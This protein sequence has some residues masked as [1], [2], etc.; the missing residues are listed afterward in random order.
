MAA[1][2][3]LDFTGANDA[4]IRALDRAMP[5]ADAL[6]DYSEERSF[7]AEFAE[8]Q[9]LYGGYQEFSFLDFDGNGRLTTADAD[10]AAD[11]IID[12]V[13]QDFAP[14]NVNVLRMDDSFE[15]IRRARS[16]RQGDAIIVLV[17][18]H[19]GSG[20]QAPVDEGNRRDD[21]AIVGG[22]VGVAVGIADASWSNPHKAD[23]FVNQVANFVSHEAGHTFGLSHVDVTVHPGETALMT[24]TVG[25]N[26]LN[27]P[28]RLFC[29][30]GGDHQNAHKELTKVLG[31]STRP[32]A[33]VLTPGVL[34]VEGSSLDNVL[35][36]GRKSNGTWTVTTRSAFWG[37]SSTSTYH[38]DP[39]ASPDI[40]S[41]NPFSKAISRIVIHG[42]SGDD[43][44]RIDSRITAPLYAYG[45][46]G[47]DVIQGGAANDHLYGQMGADILV[48]R[49]G[50]DDLWGDSP[51]Q[52]MQ[53]DILI[54]GSGSD[55]L[56]GGPGEDVMVGGSTRYDSS[57]SSLERLMAEWDSATVRS[58]R[59]A[60]LNGTVSG[61]LNGSTTLTST[62]VRD[63][64][65]F[66][67]VYSQETDWL[68]A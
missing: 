52:G 58:L 43:Q 35:T 28:D 44:L 32:W 1:D 6:R 37:R 56:R 17:G 25:V 40:N 39:D 16:N 33:A 7:V 21:A 62:S 66:D 24:P 54:G 51:M 29:V 42:G 3:M 55:T 46:S 8:L 57:V 63:D 11:R 64:D 53:R 2:I 61:G 15:A 22:S 45:G 19:D 10:L 47:D 14:Y 50:N 13:K 38:V 36:V 48:G 41:L 30:E 26:D 12:K 31:A 34:T 60:H 4:A 67:R 5:I 9:T 49:G 23:A 65:V 59:M 18:D 68:F 20:G 27:F